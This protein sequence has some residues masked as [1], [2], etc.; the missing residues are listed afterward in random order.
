MLAKLARR[1]GPARPA[2]SGIALA[3][4]YLAVWTAAGIIP[5]AAPTALSR[6]SQPGSWRGYAGGAILVR[7]GPY[8]FS[9]VKRRLLAACDPATAARPRRAG[10]AGAVRT[11][12][13]HDLRCLGSSGALMAVLPVTG[14]MNLSWMAAI[15]AACTAE[16]I[17]P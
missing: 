7:A 11:E 9:G 8:Q 10:L 5:F 15:G 3:R 13:T 2:A 12:L 4:G 14:I 17:T 6:V 16:K 1:A